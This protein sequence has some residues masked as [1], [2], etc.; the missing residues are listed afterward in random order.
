VA[1]AR[2]GFD[3]AAAN[4]RQVALAAFQNVEDN[5]AALRILEAEAS[6]QAEAV[7]SAEQAL[8]IALNQYR[9]GT[10]SYLNVV[11]A[12]AI[13]LNNRRNAIS[14]LGNRLNDSVALIRALGG[15]WET[16]DLPPAEAID[17]HATAPSGVTR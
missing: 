10:V 9:A 4:Y 17:R 16:A 13:A 14:I 5:L 6:A 11:T 15:G 12:Q 2:A 3:A 8:A 7:K 1:Q